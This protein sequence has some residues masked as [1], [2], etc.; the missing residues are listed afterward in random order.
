VE[1]DLVKARKYFKRAADHGSTKGAALAAYYSGDL[2]TAGRLWPEFTQTIAE[3]IREREES[4]G[5][6][7]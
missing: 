4:L 6:G 2:E 3:A 1:K 7:L 5:F